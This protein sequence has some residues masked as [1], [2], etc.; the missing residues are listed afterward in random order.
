MR[1]LLRRAHEL[2]APGWKRLAVRAGI[3][4]ALLGLFV[5]LPGYVASQPA[6]L[7]RY[8]RF[9]APYKTWS[10]S[11][12]AKVSCQRCHRQPDTASQL[13][14][15][16]RMTGEFY[17]ALVAPGRD[18]KLF[19]QPSNESCRSCHTDLRTVS[20]K[21][22]LNIPH[23][24]HVDVL[25]L[26]CV[27]CHRYLV[28]DKSPE[29]KNT[30][31]MNGCLRCHDGKRAKNACSACHTDKVEPLTHRAA[32]WLIVHP[33]KAGAACNK[34]HAWKTDWCA[35]C[36]SKRPRDHAAAWRSQHALAVAKH[37]NCEACHKADFC[38]RCHGEV[39]GLNFRPELKYVR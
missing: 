4:L 10:T 24:A 3:P 16:A 32:D 30:P 11:V 6:F 28:H 17:L 31:P 39:P 34:C 14:Y 21:G 23:R 5:L 27:D 35:D 19:E 2:G 33:A 20:P 15:G 37:R 22:D 38:I 12:H 36:H 18:P 26:K 9:D 29:G 7:G 25:K 8:P 1:R 13:T